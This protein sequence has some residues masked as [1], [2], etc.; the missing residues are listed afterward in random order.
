MKK[1][2]ILSIFA[3][4]LM[5]IMP[6]VSADTTTT[7][8]TGL[9]RSQ[10]GGAGPIVKA[11]WEMKAPYASL[12][13]TDD[14]T[15]EGA[16]FNPPG[17][18]NGAMNYSVCAIVT[19]PN[20]AADIK[21]VYTDIYYPATTAFHPEDPAHPD[22]IGGGDG[23]PD[24]DYGTSGCG[25][26]I[27]ENQLTKLAKMD[28]WNL[29][30]DTIR[31]NNENLPEFFGSYDYD[32]I[33]GQT[34]ELMKEEA[35]V[36]CSDKS[37]TYEDPAGNY[38]VEVFAL[39]ISGN[40]SYVDEP[41]F[42][43]FEYLPLTGFEVDFNAVSYG[44]VMLDV[45]KRISGDLTWDSGTGANPASVRNIGNQRL[46]MNV[47]QDDMDLGYT[48]EVGWNVEYDARV[49]NEELNWAYYDPEEIQQLEDILDLS[50]MEEMDFSIKVKKFPSTSTDYSGDMTLSATTA[51]FRKCWE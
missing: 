12:L 41:D 45:H 21:N 8:D 16:Q 33:C 19:D 47:E 20:G 17:V 51:P 36:Y 1:L 32:E 30:C 44:E 25:A 39:D 49:G 42:N 26:F 3:V 15:A 6:V 13:G 37:L 7:I 22:Q 9:T 50:E 5:G 27:E 46:W 14:S 18:Y 31:D 40:F 11:K 24:W 34:G 29:F 28:G 35:Y 10:G 38:K 23:T 4:A 48:T 43:H 2:I